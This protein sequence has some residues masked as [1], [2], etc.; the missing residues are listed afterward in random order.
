V[1][2]LI[3]P[4]SYFNCGRTVGGG[5]R[6]AQE[7]ARALA[8]LTPTTMGLF[9]LSPARDT[10]GPLAIRVFPVRHFRQRLGF[11]ATVRALRELAAYDVVHVMVFP[12][13][14]TDLLMLLGWLRRQ[15]VVLTDIGG[16]G[17][18]W[19]TRLARLSVRLDL[20]RRAAGLA[21]L[22]RYA[23]MPYTAWRCPQVALYGGARAADAQDHAGAEPGGYALFVGRLLPHKGALELIEALGPQTPLR[24][25][26]R[27]YDQAYF[28]RL[29]EA[30]QGKPVLFHTDADDATLADHYRGASVVVQP[31][32]PS[33]NGGFDRAEL[34]GLVALEGMSWGKPVVVTRTASLSETSLD[35]VTG[36]IVPPHDAT[37][38]RQAVE[39]F[40]ADPALSRRVGDAARRHV[41]AH[42]T[43]EQAARRGLDFYRLLLG[44]PSPC[45]G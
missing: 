28:E 5:E 37:A 31:T 8:G 43:W 38:L 32:L 42:Y 30:A 44:A 14:L 34:L 36:R 25:V 24:V 16:G 45:A 9:G 10:D 20:N 6:Y 15:P 41:L 19:S 4:P 11:P 12:T 23:G 2:V 7:Y 29:R 13:P 35:G 18:C 21:H 39:A 17:A 40:V 27:V 33:A 26:G 1:R 3:V 22:S